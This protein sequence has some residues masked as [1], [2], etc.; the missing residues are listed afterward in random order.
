MQTFTITLAGLVLLGL[1][2]VAGYLSDGGSVGP[3]AW[4]FIPVWLVASLVTLWAG[5]T[6]GGHPVA[7]ELSL[8]LINFGIPAG[9]AALI[10]RR[11]GRP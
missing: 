7:Q 4:L 9:I 10:A 3:A 1:F 6:R 5:V 8:L 11:L 2:L